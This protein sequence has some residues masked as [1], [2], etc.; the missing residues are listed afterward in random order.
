MAKPA[1]PKLCTYIFLWLMATN[2][3]FG[4]CNRHRVW[5]LHGPNRLFVAINHQ[6]IKVHNLRPLRFAQTK[7]VILVLFRRSKLSLNVAD[8]SAK[9]LSVLG[10]MGIFSMTVALDF[11][12]CVG[13]PLK[14]TPDF[15]VQRIFSKYYRKRSP[16]E[17]IP[18]R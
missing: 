2:T 13:A 1:Q 8:D 6:E 17:I 15:G 9:T 10:N 18:N 4:R 5:L 3:R 7:Q 14:N 16:T 12:R 11:C